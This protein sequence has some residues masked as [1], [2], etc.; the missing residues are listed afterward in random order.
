MVSNY[1]LAT[2]TPLRQSELCSVVA[3]PQGGALRQEINALKKY[4]KRQMKSAWK[5]KK[6]N[7][8][9]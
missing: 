2:P 7:K 9:C 3:H 4:S 1:S 8:K 6:E 5:K